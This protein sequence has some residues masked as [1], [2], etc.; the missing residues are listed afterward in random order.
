M[1]IFDPN[2][3]VNSFHG[4]SMSRASGVPRSLVNIE[5]PKHGVSNT[6]LESSIEDLAQTASFGDQEGITLRTPSR[7][8]D[9][10]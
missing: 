6:L 2:G 5:K 10:K 3:S 9:G 4:K 7:A 1:N 8:F